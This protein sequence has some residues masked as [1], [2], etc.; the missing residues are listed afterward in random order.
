LNR[1]IVGLLRH[2]P[3]VAQALHEGQRL[4]HGGRIERGVGLR[5]HDP[6]AVAAQ[7]GHQ[8][9]G[10]GDV[11][12]EAIDPVAAEP[13]RHCDELLGGRRRL[14]HQL[15][16]VAKDQVVADLVGGGPD[17]PGECVERGRDEAVKEAGRQ[18]LIQ[19]LDGL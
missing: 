1:V 2:Q 14:G 19:R 15:A 9:V 6:A 17:V 13:L 12:G 4:G 16:V 10:L 18:R 11:H 3:L 8:P 7:E 5:V